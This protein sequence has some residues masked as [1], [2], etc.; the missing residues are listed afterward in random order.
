MKLVLIEWVD[1]GGSSG[2]TE[3]KDVPSSTCPVQS[4]GWLV[5]DGKDT[6]TIVSHKG[7]EDGSHMPEQ[8]YGWMVIPTV[9]IK[10]ILNLNDPAAKKR[11]RRKVS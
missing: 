9:A 2:W 10:R 8:V 6:K 4:V 5:H 11:R 1:S 3:L 7:G